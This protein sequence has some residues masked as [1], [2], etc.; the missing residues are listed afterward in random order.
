MVGHGGLYL[1][2]G[3]GN[4]QVVQYM[5]QINLICNVVAFKP[6]GGGDQRCASNKH[7]KIFQINTRTPHTF[8]CIV[9]E[10]ESQIEI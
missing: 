10:N 7:I 8:A 3:N 6:I 1:G 5:T 2:G 9:R 4:L